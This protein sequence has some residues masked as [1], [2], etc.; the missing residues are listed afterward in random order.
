ML[1]DVVSENDAFSVF[2][3]SKMKN[4]LRSLGLT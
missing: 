4:V 1:V 3:S 2:Q